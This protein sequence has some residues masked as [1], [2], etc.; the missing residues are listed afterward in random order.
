V[1]KILITGSTGFL[2]SKLT[3]YLLSQKKYQLF[4]VSRDWSEPNFSSDLKNCRL[5]TFDKQKGISSDFKVD[6]VI[7]L[8]SS[9]ENTNEVLYT[10]LKVTEQIMNWVILNNVKKVVY[11]SSV[12]IYSDYGYLDKINEKSKTYPNSYYGTSKLLSQ[13]YIIEKCKDN[14]INYVILSPSNIISTDN[15]P[16]YFLLNFIK[17]IAHNRFIFFGNK[18]YWLNYISIENV[19]KGVVFF[20]KKNKNNKEFILN[21]PIL[22]KEAVN[23]ISDELDIKRPK[24]NFPFCIGNFIFTSAD[25]FSNLFHVESKFLKKSKFKEITNPTNIDG[26][27]ITQYSGFKYSKSIKDSLKQLV[28]NYKKL[29]LV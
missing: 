28:I 9:K 12:S 15:T 7:H 2:G 10:N 19:I 23:I 11:L 22:L 17:S 29:K 16:P 5:V 24:I 13:Q 14:N 4:L 8:A 25:I 27:S 21:T 26:S 1:L 18:D 3:K 20:I 6:I